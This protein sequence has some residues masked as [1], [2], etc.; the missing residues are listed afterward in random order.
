MGSID[1]RT[2]LEKTQN[3]MDSIRDIVSIRDNEHS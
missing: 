3:T 2:G 1:S